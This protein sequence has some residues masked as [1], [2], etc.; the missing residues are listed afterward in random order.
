MDTYAKRI[1]VGA[2]IR[3]E[4]DNF[5]IVKPHY[6][7]GWLFAGGL[8]KEDETP[9]KALGREISEEVGLDLSVGNLLCVDY[10]IRDKSSIIFIFDCG[11]VRSGTNIV[12]ED[13]EIVDHAFVSRDE[14]MKRLRPRGAKRLPYVL[15]ALSK[16]KPIY[17]ESD[18]ESIVT[19]NK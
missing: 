10:G 7:D 17:I 2:L 12:Y 11:H 14:A 6:K 5:L 16:N 15:D 13:G 1:A 9:K 4:K 8:V 3:D 19:S 18:F